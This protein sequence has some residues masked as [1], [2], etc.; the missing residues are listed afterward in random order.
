MEAVILI[1]S[2]PLIW[3][4]GCKVILLEFRKALQETVIQGLN[5]FMPGF[6]NGGTELQW[7]IDLKSPISVVGNE[8]VEMAHALEMH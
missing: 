4:R 5:A 8:Y 7:N 6:A 3:L 2:F 1:M